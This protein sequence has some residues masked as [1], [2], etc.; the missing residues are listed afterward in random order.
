MSYVHNTKING[1]H[2]VR[3][4]TKNFE[5]DPFIGEDGV[6]TFKVVERGTNNEVPNNNGRYKIRHRY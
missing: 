4:V 3:H 6:I 1:E 5:F 2:L